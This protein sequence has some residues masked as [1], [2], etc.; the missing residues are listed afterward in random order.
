MN[1]TKPESRA[2]RRKARRRARLKRMIP[3]LA[4]ALVIAAGLLSLPFALRPGADRSA[5]ADAPV[6]AVPSAAADAP[7]V[8]PALP[9]GMVNPPAEA[10]LSA[11]V[12]APAVQPAL[13]AGMVTAREA[14][15]SATVDDP[16]WIRPRRRNGSRSGVPENPSAG[17]EAPSDWAE[18]ILTG[19]KPRPDGRRPRRPRLRIV[20]PTPS[21]TPEPVYYDHLR[22]RGLHA[23]GDVSG[24]SYSA[25]AGVF[26]K[27]GAEYFLKKRPGHLTR[28]RPDHRQPGGPADQGEA[29]PQ[30]D[31]RVKGEPE[32]VKI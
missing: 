19:R 5:A 22:R 14:V 12:D 15:L 23:G 10:V 25:F 32:Y 4:A 30:E 2:A 21:P 11:A 8:Q 3:W 26:K 16:A 24:R 17:T 31:V 29:L 28:G 6:E 20:V 27:N 13:P 1:G 9:A 18:A 7:A